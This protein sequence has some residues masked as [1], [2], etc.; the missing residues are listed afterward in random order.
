MSGVHTAQGE[1]IKTD[2]GGIL[3]TEHLCR[4]RYNKAATERWY[5]IHGI[6]NVFVRMYIHIYMYV[7]ICDYK[8][9]AVYIIW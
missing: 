9:T 4:V 7:H 1:C 2:G 6:M 3:C 5:S 8:Q